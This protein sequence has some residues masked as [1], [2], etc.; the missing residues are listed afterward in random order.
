MKKLPISRAFRRRR[1]HPL[2]WRRRWKVL[3]LDLLGREESPERVAAAI[4]VGIGVGFS[5]FLGFHIWIALGLAFLLRLN[6]IDAA[7]GQF[8]GNPWTLPAIYALGYRLGR[9]LLNYDRRSVPSLAWDRLLHSDFWKAFKGAA[10]APRLLSFLVGTTVI[11]IFIG[12]MAY[13]LFLA[14]LRLY[15]RRHPRVAIRA[16]HRRTSEK[17]RLRRVSPDDSAEK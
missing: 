1:F 14:I 6:K 7:L 17:L 8:V 3:V 16:A 4:A 15:H 13:G 5:P 10:F 12:V 9:R 2:T 11:A